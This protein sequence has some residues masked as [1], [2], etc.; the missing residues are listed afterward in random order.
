MSEC[1][2]FLAGGGTR[3]RAVV[4]QGEAGIGKSTFLDLLH[5]E[6]LARGCSDVLVID[7][8]DHASDELLATLGDRIAGGSR[9]RIVLAARDLPVELERLVDRSFER[10]V[11]TMPGLE[12]ADGRR[13]LEELGHAPWSLFAA[14]VLDA[15]GGNPRQLIDGAFGSELQLRTGDD[16]SFAAEHLPRGLATWLEARM[17]DGVERSLQVVA[18]ARRVAAQEGACD[19][20]VEGRADALALLA[21][22]ELSDGNL[23]DAIQLGSIAASMPEEGDDLLAR[24]WATLIA[25]AARAVRGEAT[26]MLSLHALAGSASRAR[27]PLLEIRAWQYVCRAAGQGGDVATA[28][29]ASIRGIELADSVGAISLG[30]QQRVTLCQLHLAASE[31]GIAMQYAQEIAQVADRFDY[32]VLRA[33]ALM[34]VARAMLLLGDVDGSRAAADEAMELAIR[35]DLDHELLVDIRIAAARSNAAARE[36]GLALAAL[37]EVDAVGA[38]GTQFWVALEAV[39]ILAL[40]GNDPAAFARWQATLATFTNDEFG[41][42]LRAAHAEADAWRAAAEGRAAEAARLAQRAR[43]LWV[44][45]GC[46]EELPLTEPLVQG[47]PIEHGPRISLV[48]SATIP[49]P[50]EDPAAFEALTRREREI[51]RY[52]AGGLTNPE[53][54]AELHLSPRTVEH[55]VASILRKLELPN[56]RALVRGRV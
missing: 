28:R 38:T 31:P 13:V 25:S 10:R 1:A 11:V 39:R 8:A 44:E 14:Q 20:L 34:L 42:A 2:A 12:R 21:E 23:E 6:V 18:A 9:S 7:D 47:A 36:F 15:A 33:D 30:L 46:N 51:A 40:A 24:R 48:G 49:A 53:I 5:A 54:A 22:Q 35:Q 43:Q 16:R 29:R 56:R 37:G 3:P 19:P 26:A 17:T 32:H 45:A 50:S 52:V 55:H 41:G 4:V 27:L